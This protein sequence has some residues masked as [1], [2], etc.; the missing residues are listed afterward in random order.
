MRELK[1]CGGM[2]GSQGQR[3]TGCGARFG[4][5]GPHRRFVMLPSAR[6][7]KRPKTELHLT[8]R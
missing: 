6:G 5:R 4:E 1:D 8:P 7:Q 3:H 2:S